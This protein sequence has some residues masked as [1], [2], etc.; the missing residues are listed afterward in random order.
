MI[1]PVGG[2]VQH[3]A[4]VT[5]QQN[6]AMFHPGARTP[7]ETL[8]GS[9]MKLG[10][11]LRLCQLFPLARLADAEQFRAEAPLSVIIYA[12]H[13]ACPFCVSAD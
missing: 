4:P 6:A 9:Q 3:H 7:F 13:A 8:S 10:L 1:K 2:V 12:Q 5:V 11:N